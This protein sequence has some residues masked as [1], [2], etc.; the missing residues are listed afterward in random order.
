MR[1]SGVNWNS[2]GVA[3]LFSCLVAMSAGGLDSPAAAGDVSAAT[4]PLPETGR[5]CPEL[6][7]FDRLMRSFVRD[8]ELVGALL[9]VTRQGRL[10][11]ARGFGYADQQRKEPVQPGSL[12]RL[13]S[14]SK[15]ITAVA[16]LQ[17]VDR[18]RLQ[19]DDHVCD[20][21]P[22]QPHVEPGRK[23]DPRWR[24]IT[25]REVLQHRGGWDRQQSMDPMF[26]SLKIAAS[27]GISPPPVPDDIVRFMLGQ[28]LDFDPGSRYA[29]S[30]FGYCLLGR[31]IEHVSGQSYE[32]AVRQQL[33]EPL[34]IRDMRIGHT[35]LEQ[36]AT[37][38]VKYYTRRKERG[39]Q[40]VG[41]AADIA[42]RKRVPSQYGAWCL[43]AMD[44]HGGW[45]GSAIDVVRFASQVQMHE[46]AGLLSPEMYREMVAC[47]PGA[48]GHDAQG[49]QQDTFYGLGW[50]IR[51]VRRGRGGQPHCNFWHTGALPGTSTLLVARYDGL[52]WAVLFNST[53]TADRQRPAAKIDPLVH[54]AAAAVRQWPAYD[55][56]PD[57]Q[58]SVDRV[59]SGASDAASRG[60]E[61]A[62]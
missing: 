49:V 1:C 14:V 35:L 13:A 5:D 42:A 2:S 52:C 3:I 26:S 60:G 15:P 19:L 40:V 32:T 10:V 18:H 53:F 16:L 30:N 48:A 61:S 55:L 62:K 39:N 57:W 33:L 58:R 51:P 34:G 43:E 54:E 22:Q 21:L 28:S 36:R 12:F 24:Q 27:L 31:I 20:L 29:Y 59:K 8:N 45:I 23:L 38:E 56:F 37:G 11:Y 46:R 9:A 47:P 25:V 41:A 44:A 7:S 6:A 50:Q 4:S 17:L